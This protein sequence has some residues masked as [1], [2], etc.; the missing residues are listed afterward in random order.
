[1]D[2]GVRGGAGGIARLHRLLTEHGEAIRRDLLCAGLRL[3]W[4][5]TRRLTWVD[6]RA[7]VDHAPP[8]SALVRSTT[9]EWWVTPQLHMLREI[10][11]GVRTGAWMWTDDAS[12]KQPKSRPE[13][14]PL[15]EAE[16]DAAT[17]VREKYTALPVEDVRK[18]LGWDRPE[19]SADA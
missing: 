16:R 6:L 15:T 14:I 19:G 17:P 4:L 11:H 7:F 13:R 9:P 1:M 12:K 5:G 10:E 8:D 3:E 2:R 18:W